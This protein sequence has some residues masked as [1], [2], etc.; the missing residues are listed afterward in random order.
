MQDLD[1]IGL[2]TRPGTYVLGLA[3]YIVTFFIRRIVEGIQPKWKKQADANAAKTTYLTT[4]SRWWNEVILYAIPVYFGGASGLLK[5]DFFFAGIGDKG[6][7]IIFGVAVG[8]LSSFLYKCLQKV[9]KQKL[10][11]DIVPDV[12]AKDGDTP[13]GG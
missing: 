11:L 3:I 9:I 6:G 7:R 4:W 12:D 8:Y 2:L 1:I 13:A 5:S 10:G